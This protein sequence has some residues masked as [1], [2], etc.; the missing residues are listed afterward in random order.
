MYSLSPGSCGDIPQEVEQARAITD[1]V[2]MY[3]VT[4][5]WHGGDM[6]YHFQIANAMS[7]FI[8][9]PGKGNGR[10][11]P[12]LDML[13]P[14]VNASTDADFKMQMTLWAMARSPLVYGADIRSSALQADDFTLLTNPEVLAITTASTGNRQLK[15][16][17]TSTF[18]WVAEPTATASAF[19]SAADARYVA[20][21][22]IGSQST[23]AS[24]T[25]AELGLPAGVTCTVRDIWARKDIGTASN[26]S[27]VTA[28]LNAH[29]GVALFKVSGCK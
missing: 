19:P 20:L 6:T 7:Q 4:C 16:E 17:G 28:S 3:R 15:A 14:Y 11:F 29:N 25:L 21:M 23:T 12:D 9:V 18:V 1:V 13:N 22:H 27:P 10:S 2:N 26:D 5:D 8:D 24:A